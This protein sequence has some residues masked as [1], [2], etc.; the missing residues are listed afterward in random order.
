MLDI[1]SSKKNVNV[2]LSGKS[3]HMCGSDSEDLCMETGTH[4]INHVLKIQD[5]LD[6]IKTLKEE[7]IKD[8]VEWIK[9]HC[10]G[11]EY[12]I[13]PRT[14]RILTIEEGKEINGIL[15]NKDDHIYLSETQSAHEFTESD[16]IDDEGQILNKNGNMYRLWNYQNVQY[17]CTIDD[18]KDDNYNTE[19]FEEDSIPVHVIMPVY[20]NSVVIPE[21]YM[22]KMREGNRVVD[23]KLTSFFIK[24]APDY[25]YYGE[26]I[27]FVEETLVTEDII[28]KPLMIEKIYPLMVNFSYSIGMNVN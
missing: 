9:E 27:N 10:K 8:S 28:E 15:V 13:D 4:I 3:I 2:K 14:N 23:E 25:S 17:I 20:V 7:V 26:Y 1:S 6:Y 16:M 24:Y 21:N 19:T 12:Y 5:D 11:E 18:I 22:E